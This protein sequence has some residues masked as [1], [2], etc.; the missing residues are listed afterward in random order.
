MP[1]VTKPKNVAKVGVSRSRRVTNKTRETVWIRDGGKCVQCGGRT[2]L[3]FDHVIPFSLG[4]SN[5]P[6]NIQLLWTKCNLSKGARI[7]PEGRRR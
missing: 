1:D 5:G 4:G 3:H 2:D 6:E 7:N